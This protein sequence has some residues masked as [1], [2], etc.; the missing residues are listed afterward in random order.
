MEPM[1]VKENGVPINSE[2]TRAESLWLEYY[3]L[4]LKQRPCKVGW[5]LEEKLGL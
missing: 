4:S 1:T 2:T 5:V 3:F